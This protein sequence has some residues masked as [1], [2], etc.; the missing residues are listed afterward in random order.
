MVKGKKLMLYLYFFINIFLLKYFNYI[1]II[2]LCEIYFNYLN[3][4]LVV[5]FIIYRMF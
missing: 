5:Y 1:N 4:L 3:C 2:I